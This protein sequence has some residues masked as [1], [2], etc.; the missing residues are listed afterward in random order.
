[1]VAKTTNKTRKSSLQALNYIMSK[2]IQN[3][4]SGN[5]SSLLLLNKLKK[6]KTKTKQNTTLTTQLQ[7]LTESSTIADKKKNK[8]NL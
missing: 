6:K 5:L 4:K 7:N 2:R 8:F 3:K 1:M